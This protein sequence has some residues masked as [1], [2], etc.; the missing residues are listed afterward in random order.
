MKKT[1]FIGIIVILIVI[2]SISGLSV[3]QEKKIWGRE[4]RAAHKLLGEL[5]LVYQ[6]V[7]ELIDKTLSEE[8]GDPDELTN[9]KKG[10]SQE[11]NPELMPEKLLDLQ[12]FGSKMRSKIASYYKYWK[13]EE[14]VDES[15]LQIL[16]NT[17]DFLGQL[18]PPPM[19]PKIDLN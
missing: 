1:I 16:K 4:N 10:F 17:Y 9:F 7:I 18:C 8:L 6:Q 3:C 12:N 2:F 15:A 19:L 11:F 5:Q 13:E 14:F